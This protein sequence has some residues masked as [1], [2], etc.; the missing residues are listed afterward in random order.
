MRVLKIFM[1][2]SCFVIISVAAFARVVWLPDFQEYN[3]KGEVT[4]GTGRPLDNTVKT[5]ETYGYHTSQPT[6]TTCT[7]YYPGSNLTCFKDCKC[8][9]DYSYDAPA[10][11]LQCGSSC[12]DDE[13]NTKYKCI[14]C[15][16]SG[17]ETTEILTES[18]CS[19]DKVVVAQE[20]LSN[21]CSGNCYKC[22]DKATNC[23]NNGGTWCATKGF[24]ADFASGQCCQ[25]SDCG[26]VNSCWDNG[27][28]NICV[29]T[30]QQYEDEPNTYVEV[31]GKSSSEYQA[32]CETK[33]NGV[34]TS[35]SLIVCGQADSRE[36]I[37]CTP[38]GSDKKVCGDSCIAMSDCC[39]DSPGNGYVCY[40]GAWEDCS[41]YANE[42]Y[43]SYQ[44]IQDSCS[45]VNI[46][47]ATENAGPISCGG[48]SYTKC[49]KC[50][51]GQIGVGSSCIKDCSEYSS[52]ESVYVA[53]VTD[54]DITTAE[55]IADMGAEYETL[56]GEKFMV[57]SGGLDTPE[58]CND[59]VYVPCSRCSDNAPV[60]N[61]TG[62]EE[63]CLNNSHCGLLET[64]DTSLHQCIPDMMT[65]ITVT[66][67]AELRA[68][69]IAVETA[70]GADVNN[71]VVANDISVTGTS[72][73]TIRK[74]VNL[75]GISYADS[76]KNRPT[77][78]FENTLS[79]VWMDGVANGAIQMNGTIAE[80]NIVAKNLN[81][82]DGVDGV[83]AATNDQGSDSYAYKLENVKVI[84]NLP[85]INS[86]NTND[87]KLVSGE[88]EFR[89]EVGDAGGNMV[90]IENATTTVESAITLKLSGY[91]SPYIKNSILTVLGK[92]GISAE[93]DDVQSLIKDSNLTINGGKFYLTG[94]V[95]GL[96]SGGSI[97]C[98]GRC[99]FY[100]WQD[101]ASYPVFKDLTYTTASYSYVYNSSEKIFDNCTLSIKKSAG[102]QYMDTTGFCKF[103]IAAVNTTVSDGSV[104]N[105]VSDVLCSR[106]G[107]YDS[108]KIL[109]LN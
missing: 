59:T 44:D 77:I 50:P 26:T 56:C 97:N 104:E 7:I 55:Q 28:D 75:L 20:P 108:S 63:G 95:D 74:G 92:I 13:G 93:M 109:S 70:D 90:A 106:T 4:D 76:S 87:V 45:I 81:P 72:P 35:G 68:A 23:E 43:I 21:S 61:G 8:T 22:E 96:I 88:I 98:T 107:D 27:P 11:N 67:E 99:Y 38:C 19:S 39:G 9:A 5:C 71:I 66:N 14:K 10:N 32:A 102:N 51:T 60:G 91:Y 86:K 2:V 65:T 42:L 73:I 37:Q 101:K 18:L 64:C 49:K 69:A 15:C 89:M 79:G 82:S 30:C 100:T 41:E 24:C 57:A 62:C 48:R 31:T 1:A 84:S 16:N 53:L 36:F 34:V 33:T 40:N 58:F 25:D 103:N 12:T 17:Y 47:W 3:P 52:P 46:Q 85:I 94:Y 83:F 6:G 54:P 80:L 29:N 105:M 78:T